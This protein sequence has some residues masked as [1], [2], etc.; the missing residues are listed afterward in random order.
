VSKALFSPQSYFTA[1]NVRVHYLTAGDSYDF[2][3][4]RVTSCKEAITSPYYRDPTDSSDILGS[5]EASLLIS[6]EVDQKAIYN[7]GTTRTPSGYSRN[8]P[9]FDITFQR[10]N[11]T[12][13]Y[14]SDKKYTAVNVIVNFNYGRSSTE[15]HLTSE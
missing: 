7:V 5:Y 6:R 10:D 4:K 12:R 14:Y 2:S 9:I 11:S 1:S 13:G 3:T 15:V 8:T